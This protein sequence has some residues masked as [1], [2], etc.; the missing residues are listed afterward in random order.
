MAFLD[1]VT[2][3]LAVRSSSLLEDSQYQPFTG[4]YDT[5]MLTNQGELP[6]RLEQLVLAI[7]RVYASTFSRR[8]KSHLRA[9]PYRLEEEKMAVILQRI[10]GARHGERFYPDFAGVA[11]SYNFYP[12]PPMTAADGIAAVALGLGKAVV[13]GSAASAS[14]RALPARSLTFPRWP[15]SSRPPRTASGRSIWPVGATPRTRERRFDLDAAEADGTLAA[16]GSTF[17]PRTTPSTT[18]SRARA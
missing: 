3:R 2:T 13:E 4:V 11:R 9:T 15:T 14:V 12:A 17:R 16:V 6:K 5:V 1:L 10:V 7:K 8:A 18:A